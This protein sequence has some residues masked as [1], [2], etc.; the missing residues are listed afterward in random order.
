[1][2]VWRKLWLGWL[3]VMI[4]CFAGVSPAAALPVDVVRI[5][6]VSDT[7]WVVT[8]ALPPGITPAFVGELLTYLDPYI[9]PDGHQPAAPMIVRFV[10]DA[11]A[12]EPFPTGTEGF[13]GLTGSVNCWCFPD[14]AD[15]A[16]RRCFLWPVRRDDA[17]GAGVTL[18]A[19]RIQ[20]DR[21]MTVG[22]LIH[23]LTHFCGAVDGVRCPAHESYSPTAVYPPDYQ[24]AYWWYGVTG[25]FELRPAGVVWDALN[26]RC[27]DSDDPAICTELA[28]LLAGKVP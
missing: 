16:S 20:Q 28:Q 10:P 23:E 12:F 24:D 25:L 3:T 4:G 6:A 14:K 9:Q 18:A 2:G 27:A 8:D 1:M 5:A 22:Y 11:S 19:V 26:D 17:A 7:L 21:S 15:D 13:G